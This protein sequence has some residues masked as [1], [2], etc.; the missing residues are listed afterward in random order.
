MLDFVVDFALYFRF[1][2]V[3]IGL[4]VAQN[5]KPSASHIRQM[6]LDHS[7]L[8]GHSLFLPQKEL[9]LEVC[10]LLYSLLLSFAHVHLQVVSA[11]LS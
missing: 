3:P 11:C 8:V 6:T 7:D 5:P 4:Y 1:V 2:T 9:F 10:F